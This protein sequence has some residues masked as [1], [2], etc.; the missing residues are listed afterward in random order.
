MI[1]KSKKVINNKT[2]ATVRIRDET[3]TKT[4]ENM[5]NTHFLPSTHNPCGEKYF[6]KK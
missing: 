5:S 2:K 6:L 1:A 3:K 4:N